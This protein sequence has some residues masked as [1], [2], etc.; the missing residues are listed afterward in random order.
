MRDPTSKPDRE[1]PAFD[2]SNARARRTG[3]PV[4]NEAA[5]LRRA[6]RAIV[7]AAER[8]DVEACKELARDALR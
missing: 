2:F 1:N 7:E 6:L 3:D 5:R 4:S 8:R